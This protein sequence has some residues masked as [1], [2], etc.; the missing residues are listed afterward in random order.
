MEFKRSLTKLVSEYGNANI[1][2]W[3]FS[4]YSEYTAT[5]I[6]NKG[7]DIRLRWFWEPAHYTAQLGDI[8]LEEFFGKDCVSDKLSVPLGVRLN[9]IV[10]EK[11]LNNQIKQ[12]DLL[13]HNGKLALNKAM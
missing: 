2:L 8:M 13:L 12:R 7:E 11:H 6:P 4:L 1:E 9:D 3:D 10:I 5:P